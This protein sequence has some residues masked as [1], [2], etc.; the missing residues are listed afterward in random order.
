MGIT[1]GERALVNFVNLRHAT[2]GSDLHCHPG[3]MARVAEATMQQLSGLSGLE[4]LD[5]SGF[6]GLPPRMELLEH[7]SSLSALQRLDLSR[8]RSVSKAGLQQVSQWFTLQSLSITNCYDL[9]DDGLQHPS[10]LSALQ[11]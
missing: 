2:V 4:S 6:T 10:G 11:S 8:W 7:L 1:M 3:R 9:D 5:L